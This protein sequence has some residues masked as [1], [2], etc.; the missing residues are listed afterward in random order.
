MEHLLFL[1]KI[2]SNLKIVKN[3]ALMTFAKKFF[4]KLKTVNN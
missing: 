2:S 1:N 4:N 3:W